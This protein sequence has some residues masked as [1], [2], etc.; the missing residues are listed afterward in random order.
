[1]KVVMVVKQRSKVDLIVNLI[2]LHIELKMKSSSPQDQHQQYITVVS[3]VVLNIMMSGG[4]FNHS[5]CEQ[6]HHFDKP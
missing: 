1:M 3:L 2:L 6:S 5:S 4:I